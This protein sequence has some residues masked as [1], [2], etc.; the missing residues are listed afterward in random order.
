MN[1]DGSMRM[2][3][4]NHGVGSWHLGLI[5]SRLLELAALIKIDVSIIT[6]CSFAAGMGRMVVITYTTA[7]PRT[8]SLNVLFKIVLFGQMI[9]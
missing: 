1:G 3:R 9:T 8:I 7:K 4:T 6:L 5:I 2:V